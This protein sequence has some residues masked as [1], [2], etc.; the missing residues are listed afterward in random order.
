MLYTHID[1]IHIV[2]NGLKGKVSPDNGLYFR[3]WEI[4]SL[5]S[6]GPLMVLHFLLH[7]S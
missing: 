4:K 5:L 2:V 7:S 1:T 6:A 3:F